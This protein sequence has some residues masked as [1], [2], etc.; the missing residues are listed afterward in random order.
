VFAV[1]Q[2]QKSRTIDAWLMAHPEHGELELHFDAMR[3]APQHLPRHVRAAVDAS[4]QKVVSLSPSSR[5]L[6]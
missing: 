2:R 3:I 6:Q 4:H 5:A 1:T